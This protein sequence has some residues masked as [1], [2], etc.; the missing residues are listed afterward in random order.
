[1]RVALIVLYWVLMAVFLYLIV[2]GNI[3][4]WGTVIYALVVLAVMGAAMYLRPR[5]GRRAAR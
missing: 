4:G 5:G 3:S 1:M 2:T